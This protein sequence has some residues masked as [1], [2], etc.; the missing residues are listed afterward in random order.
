MSLI[1]SVLTTLKNL[2][3]PRPVQAPVAARV[4]AHQLFAWTVESCL[5]HVQFNSQ[6][7]SH[8]AP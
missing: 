8:G 7:E 5:M 6:S 1:L 2:M 3:S 4:K